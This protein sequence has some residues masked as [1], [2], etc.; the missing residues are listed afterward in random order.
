MTNYTYWEVFK[1][2]SDKDVFEI[3]L[4]PV[5]RFR[6]KKVVMKELNSGIVMKE[7][8]QYSDD[9]SE[10]LVIPYGGIT[11]ATFKRVQEYTKIT[12]IDAIQ[13]LKEGDEVFVLRGGEYKYMNRYTDFSDLSMD[14][15]CDFDNASF[16]KKN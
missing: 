5:E 12:F 3:T 15:F 1:H 9:D 6:G 8:G 2:G 14:D 13:L 4:S 11:G 7:E 10:T 16:Y